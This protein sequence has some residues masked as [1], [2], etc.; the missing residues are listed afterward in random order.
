MQTHLLRH[1]TAAICLFIFACLATA[2]TVAAQNGTVRGVITDAETGD[3]LDLAHVV[4]LGT[5]SGTTTNDDGEYTLSIAPG[6]YEIEVSYTGY[7]SETPQVVVGA[8]QTLVQNFRLQSA[9][10]GAGDVYVVSAGRQREKAQEAP[11]SVD[12]IQAEEVATDV[13]TSSVDVLR[14]TTAV[15]MQQTGIDRREMVIRGFN[16]AFSGATYVMT[17][18]RQAAAASL[19]ANMYSIMPNM[20]I[21][22]DRIEVVRGPGSALYGA[23]VDAGVVHFLTKDP[24]TYPGTTVSVMGGGRSLF[25]GQFRHAGVVGAN[26]RLGY[27]LTGQY[28]QANDWPFS[29]SVFISQEAIE[30]NSDY[31]KFNVNGSV[32]YRF[33]D[34]AALIL[35]GGHSVLDATM[36]SGVGTLQADGFGY[37]YAQ[38]RFQMADFFAQVYTNMNSAGDSFVYG[39][40]FDMDGIA[41]PVTDNG[42]QVVAN[43]QHSLTVADGRQ[44]F[45]YGVDADLT[46]PDTE[47]TILGRNEHDDNLDEYGVYAQSTTDLTDQLKLTLALRGDYGSVQEKI[48]LAPRAAI[49]YQP[50][51]GHSFR[52]T[53]NRAFSS[54]GT[55]SSFLDLVAANA[56]GI[57]VRARGAADGYTWER[58]ASLEPTFGT[59]LVATSLLPNIIG[60]ST[61]VGAPHTPIYQ[62]MYSGLASIDPDVLRELLKEQGIEL[63][64]DQVIFVV[65]QLHPDRTMVNGQSAGLMGIPSLSGEDTKFITDLSDIRPLEE[66]NTQTFEVGYRGLLDDRLLITADVYYTKRNNF[67]GPL[68]METPVVVAPGLRSELGGSIADGI[69][70]NPVLIQALQQAGIPPELLAGIMVEFADANLPGTSTPVAIVQP[71]ENDPGVGQAPELLLTFRNF[72]DVSFWGTDISFEYFQSEALSVFANVS[73]VS[74]DLFTHDELGEDDESLTLALNAPALKGRLGF[75]YRRRAGLSFNAA[76]RYTDGFPMRTGP[77]EGHVDSY[78]VLDV[79]AGYDLRSYAPGLRVDVGVSNVLDNRHR[80]FVGAPRLGRMVTAKMTFSIN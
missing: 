56:G 71:V 52:A 60:Q 27:K 70:A 9:I 49:V 43:V 37:T 11:A 3:P 73:I 21:D 34:D 50:V 38:L 58:D 30:R 63:S 53:Y 29:D 76:G 51:A 47:G 19:G 62:L 7:E 22:V 16:N 74:D 17:D 72:G 4:A 61:G 32:E 68:L 5:D 40:D 13:G 39:Q 48:Q 24:F 10:Y 67:V 12:V 42:V 77:Y 41:D 54:M 31:F 46:R 65:D 6:A 2:S 28:A 20:N 69:E 26:R 14:N 44:Q 36:L 80:E 75:D 23:G 33:A 35:N 59:D 79:G 15:D 18:Y 57:T 45:I 8:G 66:T 78:F 25:G 55:N 64:T 1:T